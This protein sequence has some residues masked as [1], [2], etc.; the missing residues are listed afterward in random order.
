M[1][2]GKEIHIQLTDANIG[3]VNGADWVAQYVYKKNGDMAYRIIQGNTENF[4]YDG[5]LMTTADG[6]SLGWDDNGN[7]LTS[8]DANPVKKGLAESRHSE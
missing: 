1:Q 2:C 5:H 7:L 8:V 4:S 6:N 3:D